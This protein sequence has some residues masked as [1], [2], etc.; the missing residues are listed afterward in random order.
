[1]AFLALMTLMTGVIKVTPEWDDD[2]NYGNTWQAVPEAGGGQSVTKP[3]PIC[4][5]C[6]EGLRVQ[7]LFDWWVRCLEC[8][9]EW[10]SVDG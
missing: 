3:L 4:P 6:G 7:L 8:Y 9:H 2:F 5:K 1:M 10:R